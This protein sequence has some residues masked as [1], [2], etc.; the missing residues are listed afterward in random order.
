[1]PLGSRRAM[2]LPARSLDWFSGRPAI[3]SAG[4][5]RI[6][7]GDLS[8]ALAVRDCCSQTGRVVDVDYEGQ[9]G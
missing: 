5:H 7:H 8:C 1:M 2:L 4:L 6:E 3:A 9:T